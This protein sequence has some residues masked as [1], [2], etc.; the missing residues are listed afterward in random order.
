MNNSYRIFISYA[1]E[2]GMEVALRLR[3]DLSAAGHAVWLDLAEIAAGGSWARDIEEAIEN[4]DLAL[5]LLSH[6]SY[7]SDICRGE[8]LRALRKNKRV[9]PILLQADADRPLHLEPSLPGANLPHSH[10]ISTADRE[11]PTIVT[12]GR[13]CASRLRSQISNQLAAA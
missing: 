2:D 5:M 4:C 10:S 11:P 3:N 9:I 13:R 8:Q 1:R 12:E 7:I 6:G